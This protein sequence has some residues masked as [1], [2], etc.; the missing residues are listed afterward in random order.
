MSLVVR[1]FVNDGKLKTCHKMAI[2]TYGYTCLSISD[3]FGDLN[4]DGKIQRIRRL[5]CESF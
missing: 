3:I 1:F 2:R 5:I 4:N